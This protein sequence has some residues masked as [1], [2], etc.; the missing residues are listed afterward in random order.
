MP[1]PNLNF[2]RGLSGTITIVLG[3]TRL[4]HPN[5]KNIISFTF[6]SES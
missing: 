1:K 5:A 2:I 6:R 4:R 3:L